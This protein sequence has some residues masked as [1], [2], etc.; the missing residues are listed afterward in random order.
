MLQHG[1]RIR[2]LLT[3]NGAVFTATP[4]GGKVLLQ[5]ELDRL[6]I[7]AKNSR[8][9]HP[10]TCGKVERFHQTAYASGPTLAIGPT[11]RNATSPCSLARAVQLHPASW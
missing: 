6:G 10:Q 9:Y 5:I 7:A 2:S 3:D 11:R 8:P 4:R 1:I